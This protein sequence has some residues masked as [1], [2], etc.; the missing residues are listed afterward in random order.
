[1]HS[2]IALVMFSL[3]GVRPVLSVGPSLPTWR[4]PA[5]PKALVPFL[6]FSNFHSWAVYYPNYIDDVGPRDFTIQM[7]FTCA[8]VPTAIY[9]ISEALASYASSPIVTTTSVANPSADDISALFEQQAAGDGSVVS[10]VCPCAMESAPLSSVSSWEITEDEFCARLRGLTQVTLGKPPPDVDAIIDLLKRPENTFC[11]GD[12]TDPSDANYAAFYYT[13]RDIVIAG[14][15]LPLEPEVAFNRD[16][17]NLVNLWQDALCGLAFGMDPTGFFFPRFFQEPETAPSP[18]TPDLTF[19]DNRCSTP[20]NDEEDTLAPPAFTYSSTPSNVVQL[21]KTRGQVLFGT[22]VDTCSAVATLRLGFLRTVNAVPLVTPVA[23]SPEQLRLEVERLWTASRDT[24]GALTTSFIP[25]TNPEGASS[26]IFGSTTALS[27]AGGDIYIRAPNIIPLS[28]FPFTS[29]VPFSRLDSIPGLGKYFYIT[30]GANDPVLA[31]L[32]AGEARVVAET[33]NVGTFPYLQAKDATPGFNFTPEASNEWVPLGTDYL[34]ILDACSAGVPLSI[35]VHNVR[36]ITTIPDFSILNTLP[37]LR[38]NKSALCRT[39]FAGSTGKVSFTAPLR[40]PPLVT[41]LSKLRANSTLSQKSSPLR[42]TLRDYF[43]AFPNGDDPFDPNLNDAQTAIF[44]AFFN[45]DTVERAA[46]LS[47]LMISNATFAH[48]PLDHWASCAPSSCTYQTV[49]DPV[50]GDIL[51]QA[52]T[53]YGG[54]ATTVVT[55]LSMLAFLVS[56]LAQEVPNCTKRGKGNLSSQSEGKGEEDGGVEGQQVGEGG[57]VVEVTNVLVRGGGRR[58][59]VGG[60]GGGEEGEG[61]GPKQN[62]GN[63]TMVW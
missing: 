19:F 10:L 3:L 22:A 35:D 38:V 16:L 27:R 1:M 18:I 34:S 8:S 63:A 2:I 31:P 50:L 33:S 57:A 7:L 61:V 6:I 52:V 28:T 13:I 45:G 60:M 21:Q 4:L 47:S 14:D 42:F 41:L 20:E 49:V 30:S 32:L 54:T 25:I 26:T 29:R 46:V 51:L 12:P 58:G 48:R 11:I 55:G 17:Y 44:T 15:L 53:V 9:L 36:P 59:K 39:G 62:N 37:T 40:C 5:L 56:L 24:A 43:E 23:L